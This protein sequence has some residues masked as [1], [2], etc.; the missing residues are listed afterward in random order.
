MTAQL[1]T[2]FER[3]WSTIARVYAFSVAPKTLTHMK[4]AGWSIYLQGRTDELAR[5]V[6]EAKKGIWT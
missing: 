4:E 2:E 5:V 1:K 6:R 3:A